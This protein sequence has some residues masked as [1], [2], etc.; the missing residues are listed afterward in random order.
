VG[1]LPH[2]EKIKYINNE[3]ATV[4]HVVSIREEAPTAAETVAAASAAAAATEP[5]VAKKGKP[6]D[7]AKAADAGAKKPAAKK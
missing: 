4:A 5:E 6:E 1:G 2:S 3:D 7:A